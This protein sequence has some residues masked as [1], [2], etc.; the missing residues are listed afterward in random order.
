MGPVQRY[1]IE[2][3]QGKGVLQDQNYSQRRHPP[4]MMP[5]DNISCMGCLQKTTRHFM[6]RILLS[7]PYKYY[8][9]PNSLSYSI[10]RSISKRRSHALRA[11]Q[12]PGMRIAYL[13]I[14]VVQ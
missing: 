1:P 11:D 9:E 10:L 6:S 3:I 4:A 8:V 12:A 7:R 5:S 13:F 14:A 2:R